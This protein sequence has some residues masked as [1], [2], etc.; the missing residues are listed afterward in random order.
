MRFYLFQPLIVFGSA[1]LL[2]LSS[3]ANSNAPLQT[4][5]ESKIKTPN[6]SNVDIGTAHYN[7][8]SQGFEDAWPFG[9]YSTFLVIRQGE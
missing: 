9:P 3:C 6:N 1:I 2:G 5:I 4:R 8:F 7:K